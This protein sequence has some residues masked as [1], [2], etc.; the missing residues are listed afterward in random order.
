MV[1]KRFGRKQTKQQKILIPIIGA[2]V[3]I[4]VALLIWYSGTF[5]VWIIVIT[6]VLMIISGIGLFIWKVK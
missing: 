2:V 5:W 3:G 6:L 4:I 1:S